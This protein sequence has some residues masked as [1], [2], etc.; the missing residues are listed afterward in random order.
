M[1]KAGMKCEGVLRQDF[2]NENGIMVDSIQYSIIK[3][4]FELPD[5]T[6]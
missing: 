1:E 3:Q 6:E 2:M 4:D 5:H